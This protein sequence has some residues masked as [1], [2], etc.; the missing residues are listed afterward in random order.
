MKA[1]TRI[2][3]I[4]S[5]RR[6][7]TAIYQVAARVM[8]RAPLPHRDTTAHDVTPVCCGGSFKVDNVNLIVS[9]SGESN[10]E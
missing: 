2:I 5:E 9:W 6:G 10:A 7:R 8:R 1:C 4:I 3:F